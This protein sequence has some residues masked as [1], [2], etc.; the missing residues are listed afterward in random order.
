MHVSHDLKSFILFAVINLWVKWVS[1]LNSFIMSH[2]K[3]HLPC[4]FVSTIKY[5]ETSKLLASVKERFIDKHLLWCEHLSV[6]AAALD[7]GFRRPCVNLWRN[8]VCPALYQTYLSPGMSSKQFRKHG[9]E[10]NTWAGKAVESHLS[11]WLCVHAVC[12]HSSVCVC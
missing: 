11:T 5:L 3:T 4:Y 2:T 12:V 10:M 8:Y 6:D 9:S 7:E 1:V